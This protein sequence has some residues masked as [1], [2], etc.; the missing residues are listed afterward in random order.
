MKRKKS[1]PGDVIKTWDDVFAQKVVYWDGI[2]VSRAV[3]GAWTVGFLR[4]QIADEKIRY[5]IEGVNQ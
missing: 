2:K 5:V 1:K 4:R 3:F